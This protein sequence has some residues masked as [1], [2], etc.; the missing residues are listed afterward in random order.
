[1]KHTFSQA[2]MDEMQDLATLRELN[3]NAKGTPHINR[4]RPDVERAKVEGFMGEWAVADAL[5]LPRPKNITGV[6]DGGV[7]LVLRNGDTVNVRSTRYANGSLLSP[8]APKA[9][10]LVLVVTDASTARIV[11]GILTENFMLQAE[12]RSYGGRPPCLAV[13]QDK[14]VPWAELAKALR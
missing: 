7:D 8:S 13:N 3:A 12:R 11:G 9:T 2:D 14:L 4:F 6:S 5:E 10:W 1:M